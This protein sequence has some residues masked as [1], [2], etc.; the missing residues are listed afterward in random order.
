M[1]S[2]C[3]DSIGPRAPNFVF[4]WWV[5][6]LD[7][8]KC[9]VGHFDAE[10][11]RQRKKRDHERAAHGGGVTASS[12]PVIMASSQ[13]AGAPS[14][15][16]PPHRRP[17]T[18]GRDSASS[19]IAGSIWISLKRSGWPSPTPSVILH[20]PLSS[21]VTLVAH[22]ASLFP[23]LLSSA[24]LGSVCVVRPD[25][26]SLSYP[27]LPQP[28]AAHRFAAQ[29]RLSSCLC[30]TV[31]GSRPNAGHSHNV[32]LKIPTAARISITLL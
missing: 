23:F 21:F 13:V 32:L 31:W 28:P 12:T 27:F 14:S 18:R 3:Q 8:H 16:F 6:S 5:V 11:K 7:V 26:L 9:N 10:A 22:L 19:H 1:E 17:P 29:P 2:K 20:L 4:W 24:S 30:L 25:S 15:A